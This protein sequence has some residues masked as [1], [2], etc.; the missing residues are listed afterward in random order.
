MFAATSDKLYN[1]IWTT[2]EKARLPRYKTKARR[3]YILS[4]LT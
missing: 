1:I 3:I 4:S 2:H